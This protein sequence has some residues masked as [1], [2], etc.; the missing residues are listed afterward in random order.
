MTPTER[1]QIDYALLRQIAFLW[2]NMPDETRKCSLRSPFGFQ[3]FSGVNITNN[4]PL[5]LAIK[6]VSGND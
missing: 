1:W 5:I 6:S 3:R 2:N 4:T